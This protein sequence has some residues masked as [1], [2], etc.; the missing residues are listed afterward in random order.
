MKSKTKFLTGSYR[1]I[2]LVFFLVCLDY[3]PAFPV[4]FITQKEFVAEKSAYKDYPLKILFKKLA[5]SDASTKREIR[6]VIILK[7]VFDRNM[8]EKVEAGVVKYKKPYGIIKE[9]SKDNLR[10][11][12]PETDSYRD[13]YVGIDRIPLENINNFKI[14][15]SNIG[16]YASIVYTLD[17]RIYKIKIDFELSVP[18]GLYVKR[19]GNE[20]IVGWDEPAAAQKP[21]GYKVFINREPFKT[22]EGTVVRVPRTKGQVDEYYVKAIYKHGVSFLDSEASDVQLDEIT[23]KEINQELL[24][25]ETYKRIMASLNPAESEKASKLLYDNQQLLTEH[26]DQERKENT[27]VLIGFFRNIDEGDRLS[28]EKPETVGNLET[29]LSFYKRAEQKAKALPASIDV[30]FLTELK[31]NENLNRKALLET[32][33]QEL[34][35]GETYKRIMASLNPAESEKAS[36]LLYDNQQLLT[37]HLDQ[38]RKEN[39]EVLIGFFRNIDEGDRLSLEKPETVGNLETAL[40]FYKRAEQKAKALPA[41]IDVLF[42]TELKIN[43]NLNR[44]ALLETRQQELLAAKTAKLE[45]KPPSKKPEVEEVDQSKPPEK[46]FDR[47]TQIKLAL[48]DFKAKN[49][50][51]SL[52]HFMKVFNKQI[53]NIKHGGKRQ[54]Y[55]ILAL[56]VKCRAEIVFLIELDRL[57][58]NNKN[59]KEAIERGLEEINESIDNREG[60]WIIIHNDSKRR[61]I[62]R[63]IAAFNVDSLK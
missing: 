44:K 2:L 7:Q 38:E 11:W 32:R 23:A 18:T 55:G 12:I 35:A 53:N 16:K 29:A 37:E 43:E 15:S 22:V 33:Q 58:K 34:L 39:T 6:N 4:D 57:T 30:L 62:Q 1:F 47:S 41:S 19:E 3:S 31:I 8:Q 13:L 36:K 27:E 56:P 20:N 5:E 45:P 10:L 61:M 28:L 17:G 42:L 51:S 60:L 21:S 63:H 40:S 59:N 9:I 50:I 46:K 52:N 54:I 25:G 24:A 49:Y 14:T 26:L 48:K